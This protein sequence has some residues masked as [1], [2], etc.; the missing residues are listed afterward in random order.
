MKNSIKREQSKLVCYAER[1]N[2]RLKGKRI[3]T[4][5]VLICAVAFQVNAQN[6]VEENKKMAEQTV[7]LC[8]DGQEPDVQNYVEQR[9]VCAPRRENVG[10]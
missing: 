3:I 6:T 2:F 8:P 1:E 10:W 7:K 5:V 4:I 9:T